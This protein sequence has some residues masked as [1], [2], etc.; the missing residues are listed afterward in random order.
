MLFTVRKQWEGRTV[1]LSRGS[2]YCF[3]FGKNESG[4]P[5]YSLCAVQNFLFFFFYLSGEVVIGR[6]FIFK[7][8][9]N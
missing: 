4:M 2:R 8:K 6:E 3:N 9:E 1:S 7:K 5:V